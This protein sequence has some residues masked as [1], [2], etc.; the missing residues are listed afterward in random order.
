MFETWDKSDDCFNYI[1]LIEV[2][3]R[4]GVPVILNV[5]NETIIQL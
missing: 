1:F 2:V 3:P 5:D 4:S